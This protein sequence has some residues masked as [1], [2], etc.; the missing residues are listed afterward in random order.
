MVLKMRNRGMVFAFMVVALTLAGCGTPAATGSPTVNLTAVYD[1]VAA[2]LIAQGVD[3]SPG[4]FPP[5]TQEAISSV[6]AAEP[7][8]SATLLFSDDFSNVMSGWELRSDANAV[9]EYRNGEFVIVVGKPDTSLWSKPIGI[10]ADVRISVD[11]IQVAGPLKNL[12]GVICRYQDANNFYRFVIGADGYAGITKRVN[13]EVIVIS[14]P[15][16]ATSAAVNQGYA[17]NHIEAICQGNQLA[18]LVNGQLVAA[19]TDEDFQSGEIGLLASS[20]KDIGVEVHFDNFLVS[21]P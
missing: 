10:Y 7:T 5:P 11:A 3:I 20:S 4:G 15:L 17:A 16:L 6:A 2:T 14:G 1:S 8:A 19:V 18:L 9:T 13:G 21:A 12:F